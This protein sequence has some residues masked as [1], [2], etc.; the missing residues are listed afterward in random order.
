MFCPFPLPLFNTY[1]T[2][3]HSTL[4]IPTQPNPAPPPPKLPLKPLTL[5]LTE[6]K[7]DII[8]GKTHAERQSALQQW[9]FKCTCPLCTAPPNEIAQSDARRT[10][11]ESLRDQAI[12]AFQAGRTYQS[13]RITRQILNLLPRE[14]LFPSFAEHYE[15]MARIYFVLRDKE[16]A[17]K[18]ARISLEVLL[19]QGYIDRVRE[20]H[21][22]V[23]FSRFAQE[24]AGRF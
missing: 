5:T 7:K 3:P 12:S 14:E 15:N 16:N 20:E 24:E 1:L 10:Q 22:H 21:F 9:G 2:S 13:L 6:K 8:L 23:M 11:I 19:E 4:I 18:Y 17:Y